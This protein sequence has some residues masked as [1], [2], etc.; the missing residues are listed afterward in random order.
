[1]DTTLAAIFGNELASHT[2]WASFHS[3]APE[4]FKEAIKELAGTDQ[5]CVEA[6]WT[7]NFDWASEERSV[8]CLSIESVIHRENRGPKAHPF[9]PSTFIYESQFPQFVSEV[10]SYSVTCQDPAFHTGNWS[11]SF[12]A[13]AGNVCPISVQAGQSGDSH[14]LA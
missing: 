5:F 7:M 3:R 10:R 1:M 12:S 13:A 4:S 14:R 11:G 8:I 9:I 6:Q 2:F